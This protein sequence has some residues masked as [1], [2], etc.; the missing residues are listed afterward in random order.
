[1]RIRLR[2]LAVLA[3]VPAIA[4]S[5]LAL[6]RPL[7]GRTYRG[8][9]PSWGTNGEGRHV[10]THAFGG[11]ALAVSGSGLSVTVHFTSSWPLLYCVIDQPLH[12]QST[13]AVPVAANGT[14]KA[15]IAQ[16]FQGGPGAA[17]LV[18]VVTGRFSGSSVKGTIH[19]RA[20]ECSGSASF[21]ATAH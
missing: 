21:S 20:A 19:T 14:F 5:G 7:K 11:I 1:M 10:A 16:R 4:G 6:A 12:S 3:L 13:K 2:Q 17:A 9:T 15:T 18:Q 8:R